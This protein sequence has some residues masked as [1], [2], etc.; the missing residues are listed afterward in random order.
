MQHVF[1]SE[2][3]PDCFGYCSGINSD[4]G[5]KLD[6]PTADKMAGDMIELMEKKIK[7][8]YSHR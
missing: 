3:Y 7:K 5:K 1:I 4:M 6:G 2:I 8:C